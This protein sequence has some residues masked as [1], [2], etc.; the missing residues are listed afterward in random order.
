MK[1]I[2]CL[3]LSLLMI[4]PV[5]G[6]SSNVDGAEGTKTIANGVFG[7]SR[8]DIPSELPS[9]AKNFIVDEKRQNGLALCKATTL[10]NCGYID[11]NGLADLSKTSWLCVQWWTKQTLGNPGTD[12]VNE[13]IEYSQGSA[14][15]YAQNGD[16]YIYYN[17]A[18]RVEV[19]PKSGAITLAV[20]GGYEYDYAERSVERTMKWAHLILCPQSD[21]YYLKN[22]KNIW[23]YID[24][25]IDYENKYDVATPNFGANAQTCQLVWYLQLHSGQFYYAEDGTLVEAMA[26]FGIPLYNTVKSKPWVIGEEFT[27]DPGTNLAIYAVPQDDYMTEYVKPD[28]Q[29]HRFVINITEYARYCFTNCQKTGWFN[30]QATFDAAYFH[31]SNIGWEVPGTIDCQATI[32][33]LGVYVDEK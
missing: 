31:L 3:I 33:G 23:A 12:G 29:R 32:Y 11:Y 10:D 18:K 26:W 15:N 19:D 8:Y 28:G 21:V 6:C 27:S 17:D 22:L 24:F 5:F 16:R 20:N 7:N 1:K 25:S 14:I 30:D 4:I 2:L 13:R 9:T